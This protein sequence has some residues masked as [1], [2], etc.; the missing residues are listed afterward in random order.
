MSSILYL[1]RIYYRFA[2][3]NFLARK[4]FYTMSFSHL[5]WDAFLVSHSLSFCVLYSHFGSE[6]CLSSFFSL[7]EKR[8][9]RL[10]FTDFS[11]F[12]ITTFHSIFMKKVDGHL[13]K[14]AQTVPKCWWWLFDRK[15]NEFRPH[16]CHTHFI[17]ITFFCVCIW[18]LIET[19]EGGGSEITFPEQRMMSKN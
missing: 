8:K 12:N 10:K 2:G 16:S 18:K 6:L 1:Y 3:R 11:M 14:V 4:C 19:E 15:L 13:E 7:S 17:L 5:I 9:S